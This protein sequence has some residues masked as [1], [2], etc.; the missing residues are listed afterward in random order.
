[1]KKWSSNSET[2]SITKK[3]KVKKIFCVIYGNYIKYHTFSTR[4][5][6]FSVICSKYRDKDEKFFKE[7]QSIEL[8]RI[9]CLIKNM[10]L[11]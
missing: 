5:V 1:M 2:F 3:V 8:L 4:T 6:V 11:C 7:K 10:Q 9:R